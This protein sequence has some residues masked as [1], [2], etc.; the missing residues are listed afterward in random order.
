MSL[1]AVLHEVRG[2]RERQDAK[3]GPQAHAP[4]TW[5]M[6]LAE[7]VGEANQAAFEHLHP[8][9]DKRAVTR[10]RRPLSEYR[11]ELIQVAAV[12]VAA[13]EALDRESS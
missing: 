5:L 11:D 2:E 10:G 3:W 8:T 12:A 7:E 6:I 13:I 9:F 4:A 1:D